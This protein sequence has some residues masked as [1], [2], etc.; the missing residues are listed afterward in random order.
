M[1]LYLQLS[2]ISS[3]FIF[4]LDYGLGKPADEKP[5]YGSFLFGYSFWH[6][7]KALGK[8]M[9]PIEQQY[10]DQLRTATSKL[11]RHRI[12]RDYQQIV[13]TQGRELFTW[14]KVVGMCPY[15]THFWFTTLLFVG[16]Q[17][18]V[19]RVNIF[20]FKENII[21]FIMYFL[22]SHLLLR[23]FYRWT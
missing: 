5:G 13:F 16:S 18:F 9:T 2:L 22:L 3:L 17:L 8:L 15:C 4:M 11:D 6:A 10:R 7:K 14:Q 19:Q 12:K 1:S 23:L 20:Y 21:T